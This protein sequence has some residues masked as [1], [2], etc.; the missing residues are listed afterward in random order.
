MN[1]FCRIVERGS[2]ARAAEDL[3]VSSALL[4][5]EVKLLEQSLGCTL[6][7]RTTRTMSLTDHGRHYYD[8]AQSILAAVGQVE[9][10]IR[11]RSGE[12]RG[13]LRINAPS[14]Y[15]QIVLAPLLPAFL[16]DHPDLEVTF[17]LDDRVIDMVEGGFDL[18]IR[19]RADLPDSALVARR[20]ATV[21]QRLFASPDYLTRAG[22]P[23][24]PHAL[25][26]HMSAAYTLADDTLHWALKSPE[27]SEVVDL[28]PR[29]RIGSSI[30]LRNLLMAG[31]GIGALPE[32]ISDTPE[33]EGRLVRVLP[34]YE[35]P[36]RHVFAITPSRLGSD[37]KVT[38]FLDHLR[39]TL[40]R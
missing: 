8:Q 30:V 3:G 12:V 21:R 34:G 10:R 31:F 32:F 13:H 17:S 22:E 39:A 5:R 40:A 24:T 29:L 35:L 11:Q 6:L 25:R 1:A 19:A 2:F 26:D 15:G 23:T 16:A 7:T 14:S 4:S 38:A 9:D 36:E 37:A 18:S 27:N 33:A 28:R 20:L